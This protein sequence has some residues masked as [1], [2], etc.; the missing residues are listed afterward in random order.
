MHG[1]LKSL[2]QCV[3]VTNVASA[4]AYSLIYAKGRWLGAVERTRA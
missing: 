1:T 4:V 3:A 2:F